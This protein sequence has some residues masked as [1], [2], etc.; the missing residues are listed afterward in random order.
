LTAID[1]ACVQAACTSV[2]KLAALAAP[3]GLPAAL[4]QPL[5]QALVANLAHQHSRVRLVSLQALHS[6]V[7]LGMPLALMQE[8]VLP[9]VRPLAHDH[10]PVVRSALFSSVS[11]WAG[12]QTLGGGA[13]AD[14]RAANQCRAFLPLV[15]PLLL[16]GLTD[17][18]EAIRSS[19]FAQ[20]EAIGCHMAGQVGTCA[21]LFSCS[22]AS[23]LRRRQSLHDASIYLSL[24]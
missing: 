10:S 6:L 20:M 22:L 2:G 23:L 11:L 12:S 7:Q 1:C 24:G 9:A 17:E 4:Q 5:V 16:L 3:A 14:G 19:T 15:L 13:D 18:A 21:V 8:H